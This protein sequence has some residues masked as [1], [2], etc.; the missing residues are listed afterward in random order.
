VIQKQM[1]DNP[2]RMLTLAALSNFVNLGPIV[3]NSMALARIG[4]NPLENGV[5][6]F[7]QSLDDLAT[8]NFATGLFK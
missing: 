3:L 2:A 7:P 1:R 4:N 8:V 6:K 5:L